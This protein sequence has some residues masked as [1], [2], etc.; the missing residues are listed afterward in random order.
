MFKKVLLLISFISITSSYAAISDSANQSSS[1]ANNSSN[2]NQAFQ[3]F[4]NE[5]NV[6]YVYSQGQ[7]INGAHAT[8]PYTT[9]GINL[10]VEHLFDMGIWFDFNFNMLTSNNQ[11]NLGPL[12]GG[13]GSYTGN[14]A[15]NNGAAFNQNPFVFTFNGRVGYAFNLIKDTLQLTPYGMLGRNTNWA[16]S[17][18]LANGS[19]NLT[20]DYF[21]TG[22]LGAKLSYRIN[23]AILLYVDGA[24]V[25]NW[26]NSGAV[27]SIQT[28]S[29][30]YGKS[31]A[32][33]NFGFKSTIGAKFNVY[34]N[35]Q[36]G[37]NTFW[38]NFEPQSN[39]SGLMYTPTNT[40]GGEISIGLTY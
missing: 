1:S 7:L 29:A 2:L 8:A 10:E 4:Q 11:P 38:Y 19:A 37:A 39:I 23:S 33:T 24:G 36:L 40:F 13:N 30:Y 25:Y 21:Y 22:A 31:Y 15:Y 32:A 27:K 16:T 26:D 18:V 6:G 12:N 5:Y 20:Q 9:G 3:D 35:L 17:T 28:S 14:P 34:K